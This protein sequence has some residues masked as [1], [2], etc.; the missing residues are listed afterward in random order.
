MGQNGGARDEK[1]LVVMDRK[2]LFSE[3]FATTGSALS[4]GLFYYCLHNN[5][6][7]ASHTGA[8]IRLLHRSAHSPAVLQKERTAGFRVTNK[9]GAKLAEGSVKAADSTRQA[10][11][12][13]FKATIAAL[14]SNA[15]CSP[16][17]T[18]QPTGIVCSGIHFPTVTTFV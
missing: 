1:V 7:R 10:G 15:L 6:V 4:A 5:S 3:S 2:T 9:D 18:S 8:A 17:R 16:T 13:D 11:Q 14:F 12:G